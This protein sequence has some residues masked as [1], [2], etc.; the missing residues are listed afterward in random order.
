ML[1]LEFSPR[2]AAALGFATVLRL[3]LDLPDEV[4]TQVGDALVEI[5]QNACFVLDIPQRHLSA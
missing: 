5:M 4:L 1:S 3:R 2:A